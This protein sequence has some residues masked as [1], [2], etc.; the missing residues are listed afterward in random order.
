MTGGVR[1]ARGCLNQKKSQITIVGHTLNSCDLEAFGNGEVKTDG[2][3]DPR[4]VKQQEFR[5]MIK[6]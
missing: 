4:K 3:L 6:N 5:E 2:D 1:T